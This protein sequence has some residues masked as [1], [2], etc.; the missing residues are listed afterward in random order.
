MIFEAAEALCLHCH[1]NGNLFEGMYGHNQGLED[2]PSTMWLGRSIDNRA[3]VL[4]LILGLEKQRLMRMSSRT[5]ASTKVYLDGLIALDGKMG[6]W[7]HHTPFVMSMAKE[8]QNPEDVVKSYRRF[9]L[10]K[11]NR[12]NL[13]YKSPRQTPA[14]F[15]EYSNVV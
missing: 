15:E 4:Q 14:W 6:S 13:F 10:R 12:M 1:I 3:W 9:Y 7:Q 11:A 2:N 8:Y 5:H